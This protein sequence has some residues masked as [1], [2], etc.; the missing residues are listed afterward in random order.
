MVIPKPALI[1]S[2]VL[3]SPLLL[4]MGGRAADSVIGEVTAA[5]SAERR[6][7]LRTDDGRTVTV[8]CAEGAALLQARPGSK[9]LSDATPLKGDIAAGDRVLA[10]GALSEDR[11]AL[12]ARRVVVMT[13][14]DL[15]AR[16]Q[17]ER[18]DWQR[19]S[20]AGVLVSADPGPGDLT[21]RVRGTSTVVCSTSGRTVFRRYAPDS[22]RFLDARVG[23]LADLQTGD[24]VRVLGDRTEDGARCTAEQVVSGAF[25][26]ARGVV[27]SI[28]APHGQLSI[29]DAGGGKNPLTIVV[30]P[31]A[32]LRRL[33]PG[34]AARLF[35][36][37]DRSAAAGGPPPEGAPPPRRGEA[38][39]MLERLPAITL[40]DV[41]TGESV[42]VLGPKGK[43][44]ALLSAIK[45]VAGLPAA[46]PE[47]ARGRRGRG[48]PGADLGLPPGLLDLGDVPW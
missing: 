18:E 44:P 42:A 39:D 34:L 21:L 22:V 14:S 16:R 5:N 19:R 23:T 2:V 13:L 29:E 15:D 38:D 6:L 31:D 11:S 46:A 40:A 10:Q 9:T 47:A 37:P 43:D 48:T 17:Q 1:V 28:D 8:T 41:Q 12:S 20:V 25:Q 27:R 7:V 24:Q 32:V 26:T 45:L 4:P 35:R 36:P 3:G 30:K 33:P